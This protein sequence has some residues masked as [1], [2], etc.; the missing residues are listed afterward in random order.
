MLQLIGIHIYNDQSLW[1]RL[2][3]LVRQQIRHYLWKL[4]MGNED[5]STIKALEAVSLLSWHPMRDQRCY[6]SYESI[7]FPDSSGLKHYLLYVYSE[8]A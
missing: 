2:C 6:I 1:A 5:S 7:L 4:E 8:V 3:R